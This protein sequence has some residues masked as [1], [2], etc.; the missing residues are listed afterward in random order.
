MNSRLQYTSNFESLPERLAASEAVYPEVEHI[1][2]YEWSA[3]YE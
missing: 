1:R 3:D 2:C